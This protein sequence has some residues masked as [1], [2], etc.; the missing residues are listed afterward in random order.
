MP[1]APTTSSPAPLIAV[2]PLTRQPLS[3]DP[4]GQFLTTPAGIRYP[5]KNGIPILLPT[6]AIHP[7]KPLTTDH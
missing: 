3:P 1:D 2:C 5:I 6:A 7:P 4:S